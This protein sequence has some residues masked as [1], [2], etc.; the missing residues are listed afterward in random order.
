MSATKCIGSRQKITEV[1]CKAHIRKNIHKHIPAACI[2]T[3]KADIYRNCINLVVIYS[4]FTEQI[5]NSACCILPILAFH[6]HPCILGILSRFSSLSIPWILILSPFIPGILSLYSSL[7]IPGILNLHLSRIPILDFSASIHHSPSLE[8]SASIHQS[9]SLESSA[10]IHQS[11]SLVSSAL[12]SSLSVP[13]ILSLYSSLSIPGILSLYS[14]LSITG[15]L[16]LYSSLSIPGILFITLHS[17]I[18]ESSVL[19]H[20]PPPLEN[21]TGRGPL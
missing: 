4:A 21:S 7:S 15:I 9:P 12:Y 18:L 17:W 14:S 6:K 1:G 19:S 13:G 10:S 16:S 5:R 20:L 11:P 2:R 3:K 8:S